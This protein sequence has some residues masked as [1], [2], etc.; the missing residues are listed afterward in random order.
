MNN[1]YYYNYNYIIKKNKS[2]KT[3]TCLESYGKPP[4]GE[5]KVEGQENA[6]PAVMTAKLMVTFRKF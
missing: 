1:N 2:I 4:E 3:S 6:V 5:G